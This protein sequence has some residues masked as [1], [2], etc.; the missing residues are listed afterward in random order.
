MIT[1]GYVFAVLV[2]YALSLPVSSDRMAKGDVR[3]MKCIVEVITEAISMPHPLPVS[4]E[5]LDTLRKDERLL[6]ILR[7]QNFLKELQEVAKQGAS[8]R[9]QQIKAEPGHVTNTR[10]GLPAA[11]KLPDQELC[12]LAGDHISPDQSMLSAL[13]PTERAVPDEKEAIVKDDMERGNG[14]GDSGGEPES[15]EK[16]N[17]KLRKTSEAETAG[18]RRDWN[19]KME[20]QPWKRGGEWTGVEE[21][22]TVQTTSAVLDPPHHSKED[23]GE[24][25]QELHMIASK[26]PAEWKEEDGS[27]SR[28]AEDHEVKSLAAIESELENMAKKLHELRRG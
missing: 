22:S 12:Q 2:N 8:D 23:S 18:E 4:Q 19:G 24:E 26:E 16:V 1:R 17:L 20:V 10:G 11:D 3:V 9:A 15:T 13:K 6:L 27:G 21:L 7:H 14:Y 5:C 25:I 28:K